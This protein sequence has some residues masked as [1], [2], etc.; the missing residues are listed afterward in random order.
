MQ[1]SVSVRKGGQDPSEESKESHK[2]VLETEKELVVAEKEVVKELHIDE[3]KD[4]LMN[5]LEIKSILYIYISIYI[6]IYSEGIN[7]IGP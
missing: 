5:D 7:E 3:T 4:N 6:Y 1:L 2:F